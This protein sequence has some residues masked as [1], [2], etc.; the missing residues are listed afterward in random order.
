[1]PLHC[2]ARRSTITILFNLT[3][4]LPRWSWV[5]LEKPTV[6]QLLKKFPAFYGT[7]RLITLVIRASHCPYPEPHKA[8]PQPLSYFSNTIL[9]NHVSQ[10]RYC[11]YIT[12]VSRMSCSDTCTDG[13]IF[14]YDGILTFQDYVQLFKIF[15]V[16]M[17]LYSNMIFSKL[18]EQGVKCFGNIHYSY[19]TVIIC[20]IHGG[21]MRNH[22]INT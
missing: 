11:F 21:D 13:R 2:I 6:A 12:S 3:N 5:L 16:Y 10:S 1:L 20:K 19:M 14:G 7:R 22:F 4:E 8:C 18:I 17:F 9:F 15:S